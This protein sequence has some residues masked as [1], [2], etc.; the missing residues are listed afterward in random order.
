MKKSTK[1][2]EKINNEEIKDSTK[3]T[4][5]LSIKE[6]SAQKENEAT[7]DISSFVI[8]ESDKNKAE[9]EESQQPLVSGEI[10]ESDEVIA[11]PTEIPYVPDQLELPAVEL[12]KAEE[13]AELPAESSSQ[14]ETEDSHAVEESGELKAEKSRKKRFSD[15]LSDDEAFELLGPESTLKHLAEL[16]LGMVPVICA[17]A[18]FLWISLGGTLFSVSIIAIPGAAVLALFLFWA[19]GGCKNINR[20]RFARAYFLWLLCLAGIGAVIG[21]LAYAFGAELSPIIRKIMNIISSVK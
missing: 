14:K 8:A 15:Q 6:E 21:L 12:P 20:R 1:N 4:E 5:A 16:L 11:A 3:E 13:A 7:K 19:L 2:K 17:I 10:P 18:C 9:K